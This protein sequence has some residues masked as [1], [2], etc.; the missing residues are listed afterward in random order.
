MIVVVAELLPGVGSGVFDDEPV[1]VLVNCVPVN[2]SSTL[3][4]GK[5]FT[6]FSWRNAK[7]EKRAVV[8]VIVPV[9]PATGCEQLKFERSVVPKVKETKVVPAGKTSVN[10]TFCASSGP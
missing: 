2:A 3:R 5:M 7:D 10:V 6:I 8:Q 9:L 4:T 1:T